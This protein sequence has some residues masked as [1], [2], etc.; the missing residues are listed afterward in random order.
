MG[1]LRSHSHF[2]EF[3]MTVPLLDLKAQ[4]ATMPTTTPDA[5]EAILQSQYFINGPAVAELESAIAAYC[6]TEFAVGVSSGTDAL[7]AS[8]MSVGVYRSPLDEGP[9]DEVITTAYTFFATTGSIW[10]CGARPVFVDIEPDTYNIDVT[11]IEAAITER[12]KAIMP[13]HLYGQMADMD[14]ICAIAKK[15]NLAVIEDGAQA[16]GSKQNGKACGSFGTTGCFSFFPTKNLGGCGDGGMV[17]TDDGDLAE[18]L[19]QCRNHGMDPKY[20]HKWVGGNFRLDTMQAAALLIKLPMLDGWHEGRRQNAAFY[21]AAFADVAE[22]VTPTNRDYNEV[23]YNQYIVRVPNR[24]ACVEHLK[25]Q[26]VGCEIYYPVTMH[27]Q[28]CFA[29]LGYK[30]GDFPESEKAATETMALPIYPELEETQLQEV[31]D[32]LKA[33]V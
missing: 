25:A 9:A 11:K 26:G 31:V 33:F 4:Y 30:A 23:I 29:P 21:D 5:F 10:R 16:I 20:Y 14:A 15:Y 12:T 3:A 17:T 8:L 7:I 24:D 13:V 19:K 18:R 32:T 27:Q 22:V 2:L 28:E 1:V 6:Q